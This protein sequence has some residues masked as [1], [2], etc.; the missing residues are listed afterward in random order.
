ME[1]DLVRSADVSTLSSTV[2]YQVAQEFTSHHS[3]I[4]TPRVPI[5]LPQRTGN[6][7]ACGSSKFTGADTKLRRK[8]LKS[9]LL[10]E[11]DDILSEK[12]KKREKF[13][14][15]HRILCVT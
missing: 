4:E 8:N 2:I 9:R 11:R 12:L 5:F 10:S 14:H 6:W 7:N 15:I 1:V 13:A 3:E